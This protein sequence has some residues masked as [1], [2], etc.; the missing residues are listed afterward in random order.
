[1][2]EYIVK[3]MSDLYSNV[4]FGGGGG[5][6]GNVSVK[7]KSN[8]SFKVSDK[9]LEVCGTIAVPG[10]KVDGC[11]TIGKGNAPNTG[12]AHTPQKASD[13]SHNAAFERNGSK[14]P[15]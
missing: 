1:M 7:T 2:S 15:R 3:A 6:G 4:S 11:A 8:P 13:I 14:G 10:F 9:G 12:I 5:G